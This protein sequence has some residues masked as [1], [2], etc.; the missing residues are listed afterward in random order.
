MH[1]ELIWTR[2]GNGIDIQKGGTTLS[3]S[4]FKVYSC[5]EEI[6]NGDVADIPLLYHMASMKATF[7]EPNF[8]DDAYLYFTPNYGKNLLM[9]FH[10]IPFD[11]DADGDYSHRGGNFINQIFVGDYYDIYPFESFGNSRIWDAK[12]RGEAYY[13]EVKSNPLSPR[14]IAIDFEGEIGID[15][16]AFFASGERRPLLMQAISFIITQYMYPAEERKFLVIKERDSH[17]I[18]LWIAAIESAFS[19]RIASGIPFATRLDR[20]ATNNI[21]TVN[22]SGQYQTQKNLNDSKQRL[23]L[24]AMIVGADEKDKANFDNARAMQNSSFAVLDGIKLTFSEQVDTSNSYYEIITTYDETHIYFCREFLQMVN[25]T[26]PSESVLDLFKAYKLLHSYEASGDIQKC[27]MGIEILGNFSLIPSSCLKQL[28]NRLKSGYQEMLSKDATNTLSIL[29]WLNKTAELLK[30]YDSIP[31][32]QQI[33]Q[34]V[35]VMLTYSEPCN[36]SISVLW[37]TLRNSTRKTKAAQE[38]TDYS[39]FE[40]YRASVGRYSTTEWSSFMSIYS[41]CLKSISNISDNDSWI[42]VEEFLHEM[43]LENDVSIVL[44]HLTTLKDVSRDKVYITLLNAASKARDSKYISFIV[45]LMIRTFPE[46]LSSNDNLNR[47]YTSLYKQQLENY[48][49][50]ALCE[51]T[52]KWFDPLKYM[53]F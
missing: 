35:F 21:Y 51:A 8:M 5:S 3:N 22:Q 9:N 17:Q 24:H 4:G 34:Y 42:I 19:P 32:F 10:P 37:N 40:K 25:L 47:F 38:L 26:E 23:R 46:L 18:E 45:I 36:V 41:E 52:K 31:K 14:E 29:S 2:C 15:E 44:S 6:I 48:F 50:I 12:E 28:Y 13:Y 30:D 43:Y 49:P 20:Y 7:R 39:T 1:Y 11:P 27:A 33:M 53:I 16:L